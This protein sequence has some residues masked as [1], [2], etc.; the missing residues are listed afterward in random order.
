VTDYLVPVLAAGASLAGAVTASVQAALGAR[1]AKAAREEVRRLS[2]E[3]ELE[4]LGSSNLGRLGRY[5]YDD[6][7]STRISN[8]VE[9]ENVRDRVS[10]ALAGVV[11][12]LGTEEIQIRPEDAQAP[13]DDVGE[14]VDEAI[15]GLREV[16]PPEQSEMQRALSEITFGEV[17]NGLAR[18]RRH[19]EVRLRAAVQE[20]LPGD[21]FAA[22]K[23]FRARSA[24]S[25]VRILR[26]AGK[27]SSDTEEHLRYAIDIANAGV[28]GTEVDVYQAQ[29][30]WEA[31]VRGL[32]TLENSY[33][34]ATD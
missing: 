5:L 34:D 31:A 25:L 1:Q 15:D 17:W 23:S 6:I 12:F 22:E 10:R 32:A 4:V 11:E 14:P 29:S 7:G 8:Y 30:A 2:E 18:M 21:V 26:Q 27:I 16:P 28:H 13:S 24:G 19:L 33:G 3:K 20:M 9:N